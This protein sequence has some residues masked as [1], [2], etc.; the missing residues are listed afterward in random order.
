MADFLKSIALK[1][2]A[3]ELF[4]E[5]VKEE[6]AKQKLKHNLGPKHY[7]KV[8]SFKQKLE[9]LQDI[10]VEG[11]M[12]LEE[13]QIAKKR[14]TTIY[15][16]LKNKEAEV[17]NEN[18]ILKTYND[19]FNKTEHLDN[20]FNIASIEDKRKIIG[21]MFPN[22]FQFENQKVRTADVNPILTKI[23]NVNRACQGVKKMG[24]GL[25][26]DLSHSVK[27]EGFEPSTACLEGKSLNHYRSLFY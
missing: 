25:K 1:K 6:I 16:E 14:Y 5:I 4:V 20:Q 11:E 23:A 18:V 10:Y 9:R 2:N 7:E 12:D 24:Q 21:S 17:I 26:K 19:A 13:Y 27:A 8:A 3:K 22:N 15:Q